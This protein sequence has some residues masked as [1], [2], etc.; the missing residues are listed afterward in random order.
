[1]MRNWPKLAG[2][3]KKWDISAVFSFINVLIAFKGQAF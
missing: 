2:Q 3:A 1:M